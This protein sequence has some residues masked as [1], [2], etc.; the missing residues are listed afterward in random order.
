MFTC[1]LKITSV[2][3]VK[4]RIVTFLTKLF[5][6]HNLCIFGSIAA[7]TKTIRAFTGF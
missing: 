5:K 2:S 7:E 3:I 6:N 4:N 1:Y